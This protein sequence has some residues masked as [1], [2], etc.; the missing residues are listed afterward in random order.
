ML[1]CEHC[2][3][4]LLD[5][6]YGLLDEAEDRAFQTHLIGCPACAS[7]LRQERDFQTRLARAARAEFPD[8]KFAPP[9][10]NVEPGARSAET[11]AGSTTSGKKAPDAPTPH[12]VLRTPHSD[13]RPSMQRIGTRRA[14]GAGLLIV[15]AGLGAP[16]ARHF[17]GWWNQ[18]AEVDAAHA[19]YEQIDR[20]IKALVAR[21]ESDR[22]KVQDALA[23]AELTH[24]DV[25]GDWATA[26]S[27]AVATLAEQDFFVKL[28]GPERPQ[29]GAP[30]EWK[31]ETLDTQKGR[32]QPA[33]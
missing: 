24:N 5:H 23:T 19:R 18:T 22:R 31:I 33:D 15:V 30:N 8:V 32:Y 2:R 17:I 6:L 12:S 10:P 29:P 14:G 21:H 7:A 9:T 1:S 27:K 3:E 20:D 28:T 4:Q 25:L 16:A 13:D 11:K 26:G